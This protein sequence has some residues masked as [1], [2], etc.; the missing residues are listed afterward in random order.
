MLTKVNK[1]R[2]H[3]SLWTDDAD[4]LKALSDATGRTQVQLLHEAILL[5]VA[6]AHGVASFIEEAEEKIAHVP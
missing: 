5:R 6:H 4:E 3:V 1:A 2:K